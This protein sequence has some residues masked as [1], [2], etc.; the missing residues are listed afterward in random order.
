MYEK[1]DREILLGAKDAENRVSMEGSSIIRDIFV[2]TRSISYEGCG[3][4]GVTFEVNRSRCGCCNDITYVLIP[5]EVIEGDSEKQQAFI[6]EQKKEYRDVGE[7]YSVGYE[8][9]GGS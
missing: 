3:S 1:T 9:E 7:E 5:W 8:E 2:H 6:Q 4:S